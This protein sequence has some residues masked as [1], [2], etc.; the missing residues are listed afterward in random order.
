MALTLAGVPLTLNKQ[1]AG[2]AL[3]LDPIKGGMMKRIRT[4][5][6]VFIA[7]AL[8]TALPAPTLAQTFP[9]Q[10]DGTITSYWVEENAG[11]TIELSTVGPCGGTPYYYLPRSAG[12]F[13]QMNALLLSASLANKTVRLEV[14][15][16]FGD[17][18]TIGHGAIRF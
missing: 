3:G 18:T 12:N 9:M 1:S 15:Q 10:I 6:P 11:V 4:C 7:G 13:D 16:C 5:L 17:R 14:T 8:L 2:E